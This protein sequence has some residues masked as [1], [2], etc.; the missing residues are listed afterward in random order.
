MPRLP[1]EPHEAHC[2]A[3]CYQACV[4]VA[5]AI[6]VNPDSAVE[7]AMVLAQL[8]RECEQ[9]RHACVDCLDRLRQAKVI[10]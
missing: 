4:E 10:R 1:I 2:D 3:R 9:R 6:T 5:P 8:R 7:T